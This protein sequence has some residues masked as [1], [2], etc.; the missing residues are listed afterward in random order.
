MGR[1]SRR[2]AWRSS[3]PWSICGGR[4]RQLR[5]PDERRCGGRRSDPCVRTP[6]DRQTLQNLQD[7]LP[8]TSS[9][10]RSSRPPRTNCWATD[11]RLRPLA[12]TTTARAGCGGGMASSGPCTWRLLASRP[13]RPSHRWWVWSP[14]YTLGLFAF[15][16]ALHAAIKLQRRDLWLWAAGLSAADVSCGAC[17]PG[18]LPTRTG[19]PRRSRTWALHRRCPGDRGHDSRVRRPRRGV[20]DVSRSESGGRHPH[21]ARP[22]HRELLGRPRATRGVGGAEPEGPGLGEGPED[23]ETGPGPAVRRRRARRRQP[24]PRGV[25]R[26]A[27]G[28]QPRPGPDR[29]RGPGTLG[30]F[31]SA[32]ELCGLAELPPQTL[33]A[34]RDRIVTL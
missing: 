28:T 2:N 16:P 5:R 31:Q 15:I 33:D 29:G 34:I 23:R 32:T 20:R 25:P 14:T 18:A 8:R 22:G 9:R 24:R 19:A 11:A 12:G 21:R 7:L 13:G 10:K 26:V 1:R 30:G 27:P 17:S 3:F 4:G 6:G